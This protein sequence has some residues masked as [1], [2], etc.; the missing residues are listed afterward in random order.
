M[1]DD[2]PDVIIE[3]AARSGTT[4]LYR[5]LDAHPEVTMAKGKE[6][7]FFDRHY[8]RRWEWYIEQLP[9]RQ[10]AVGW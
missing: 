6:V 2:G 3:G 8:D 9:D 10:T 7:R 1:T 5:W 4:S